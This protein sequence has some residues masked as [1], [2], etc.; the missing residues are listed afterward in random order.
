MAPTLLQAA[1]WENKLY[2]L[3]NEFFYY[4]NV[5][6]DMNHM[7]AHSWAQ[8]SQDSKQWWYWYSA[9][10]FLTGLSLGDASCLWSVSRRHC[11]LPFQY[12][13]PEYILF[14]SIS[15][16]WL[17]VFPGINNWNHSLSLNH[18]SISFALAFQW[19]IEISNYQQW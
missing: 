17:C 13:A 5:K 4:S 15:C 6:K 19:L 2:L 3:T 12:F 18:V 11:N 14:G 7:W 10:V 1:G 9:F 8:G 16:L